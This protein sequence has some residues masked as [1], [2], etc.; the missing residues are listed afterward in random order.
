MGYVQIA[1]FIVGLLVAYAARRKT[2]TPPKAAGLEDMQFPQST[3]GTPQMVIF[4]DVWVRD[5][6]VLGVGN[7]RTRP[8]MK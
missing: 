8:I 4:G 1:I 3:E 2:S 6:M 7:F 5:W